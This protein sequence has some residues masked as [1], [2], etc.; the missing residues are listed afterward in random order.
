[1]EDNKI[2]ILDLIESFCIGVAS[3][4]TYAAL[5]NQV[6]HLIATI[7]IGVISSTVIILFQFFLKRK[8]RERD[9]KRPKAEQ[10]SGDEV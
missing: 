3:S 5:I 8:L 2:T 9:S 1:M 6:F 10:R 4:F 7:L